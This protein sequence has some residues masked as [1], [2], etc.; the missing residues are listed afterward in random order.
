MRRLVDN[1]VSIAGLVL[2]NSVAV[3]WLLRGDSGNPYEGLVHAALLAGLILGLIL[4]PLGIRL[5]GRKEEI[6]SAGRRLA[7]VFGITTAANLIIGSH[8]T[9]SAVRS[10]DSPNFCGTACHVMNPEFHAAGRGA[11]AG[12][13]CVDCH[14]APGAQGFIAAKTNGLHQLVSFL[15]GNYSRPIPTPVHNLPT[16]AEMCGKCH[17]LEAGHQDKVKLYVTFSS[18]ERNTRQRTA[19]LFKS[20][21]IHQA[22]RNV[23]VDWADAKKEAPKNLKG[24]EPMTCVDCHNRP[25]HSFQTAEAAVDEAL[26]SGALD[27]NKPWIRKTALEQLQKTYASKAEA[28]KTIED[29][30][31]LAI[32]NA[33]VSP[34]RKLDWGLHPNHLGHNNSPGCFRCHDEKF[35]LAPDCGQCHT[36][37]KLP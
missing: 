11:H 31:I 10:M 13:K 27:L 36:E 35:S 30:A 33:N 6:A 17:N 25:A 18:D 8:L 34:E 16:V 29:P 14:V 22:H 20:R 21:R 24:G 28:G 19:Y 37:V 7:L 23:R 5:H 12:V 9:Y 1:A 3:L 2:V 4:I 26:E 15:S 32:Y